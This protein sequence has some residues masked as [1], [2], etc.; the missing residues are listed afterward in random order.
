MLRFET[1]EVCRTQVVRA[2]P[3]HCRHGETLLTDLATVAVPR[4]NPHVLAMPESTRVPTSARTTLILLF[5]IN[6]LNFYDRQILATVT[7]PVRQ[8]FG[9]S[10]GAIGWLGTAFTLF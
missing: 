9:L 6:L 2:L 1:R 4:T 5:L 3:N 10:D 7:E 8:E